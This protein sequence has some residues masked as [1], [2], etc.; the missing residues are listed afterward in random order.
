MSTCK[1]E[2]VLEVI[3]NYTSK[4]SK[5]KRVIGVLSSKLEDLQTLREIKVLEES[6]NNSTEEY[7][8]TED[9]AS[10]KKSQ[11]EVLDSLVEEKPSID[12]DA[13]VDVV[14]ETEVIQ[15]QQ[16][17]ASNMWS[18]YFKT[19]TAHLKKA[20]NSV[21]GKL[22]GINKDINLAIA[23]VN[24]D[25]TYNNMPIG[26]AFFSK[27][28]VNYPDFVTL[29]S[30]KKLL[31]KIVNDS[32]KFTSVKEVEDK[33]NL[34]ENS[35]HNNFTDLHIYVY[36]SAKEFMET[37][38][39]D[40]KTK[41]VRNLYKK[42]RKKAESDEKLN[43]IA[44]GKWKKDEYKFI[45][46][47][48]SNPEMI[49]YLNNMKTTGVKGVLHRLI[50]TLAHMVGLKE[51]S[52]A[53]LLLDNLLWMAENKVEQNLD[54]PK[55][56]TSSTSNKPTGKR[57]KVYWNNIWY[58][59]D[60]DNDKLYNSARPNREVWKNKDNVQR[61]RIVE[62]ALDAEKEKSDKQEKSKPT[63]A[64]NSYVLF[65]GDDG[66]IYTS[67]EG[68]TK[69]INTLLKWKEDKSKQYFLLMGRGG[70]GKTTVINVALK[71]MGYTS[72]DV[73]FL[74]PS[75]KA[76]EVIKEANKDSEFAGSEYTTLAA[77]VGL[78]PNPKYDEMNP[79]PNEPPFIEEFNS[80]T[81]EIPKVV[82]IDE[83]SMVGD[84]LYQR[85]KERLKYEGKNAKVIM[86]GD[87]VQLPPVNASESKSRAF[88][89]YEGKEGQYARLTERMRQ[90]EESPILPY[91]DIL[92]EAVNEIE[93]SNNRDNYNLQNKLAEKMKRDGIT[94]KFDR[95]NN[96]GIFFTANSYDTI[97]DRFIRDYKKD[98]KG[99][100]FIHY[101]N[102]SHAK[103][104]NLTT[105]IRNEIYGEEQARN[106][107][108]IKGEH[109]ILN[110]PVEPVERTIVN[111]KNIDPE[112]NLLQSGIE[113]EVVDT[114]KVTE[115]IVFSHGRRDGLI[116]PEVTYDLVTVKDASGNRYK[117]RTIDKEEFYSLGAKAKKDNGLFVFPGGLGQKITTGLNYSYVINVH[118][119]QGSSYNTVYMDIGNILWNGKYSTADTVAKSLYVA[120]SRARKKLIVIDNRLNANNSKTDLSQMGDENVG[121]AGILNTISRGC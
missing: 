103:T 12:N 43:S 18:N 22:I 77:F 81:V 80:S 86:M 88:I 114:E 7:L 30:N 93:A 56:D 59:Y 105:R 91:T 48:L 98:P 31:N 66:T 51:N 92:A 36:T 89:D 85:V 107:K 65:T 58:E 37:N 23:L 4:N 9:K 115:K 94:S 71:E 32:D 26:T 14:K 110:K 67:N 76:K 53:T 95:E 101:N 49:D 121:N 27:G 120:A 90:K 61:A 84:Y 79:N 102:E 11:E 25:K 113:L 117:I 1:I 55:K 40:S 17:A 2:A 24:G 78:K 6:L 87:D 42:L 83:V 33:I 116:T 10:A 28:L 39:N 47:A 69:A 108:Y 41:Y 8:D 19:L 109:V 72:A 52:E 5:T 62:V 104:I 16:E 29:R 100:R 119:A 75:H 20:Y 46:V 111:D 97:L 44:K 15:Q 13:K 70:T 96:E 60:K 21:H 99:T 118:K 34:L 50:S 74:T 68:Q 54:K 38:P 57:I 112:S 35:F 63:Q 82:V 45:A 3:N 73:L 64:K 106:N